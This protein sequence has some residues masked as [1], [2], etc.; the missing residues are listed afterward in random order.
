MRASG[1]GVHASMLQVVEVHNE[2]GA[3]DMGISSRVALAARQ[4]QDA[5]VVDSLK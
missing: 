2:V 4:G 5:G 3:C 1:V